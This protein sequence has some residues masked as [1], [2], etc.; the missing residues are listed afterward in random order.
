MNQKLVIMVLLAVPLMAPLPLA[1][2]AP[3]R[4]GAAGAA[5]RGPGR[6]TP[7]PPAYPDRP[8]ADPAVVQ[9]GKASYGVNCSFCHGS[10][11]RG[12]EGGPNLLRSE[13]MLDDQHGEKMAPIVKQGLADR[14][15]PKFDMT[16]AQIADVAAFIHSF[17]VGG[18]D[19]SRMTP[20]SVLVGDAKAGGTYFKSKCGACH[21][22]TGD[23]KGLASKITDPKVLQNTWLMP[24]GGRGGAAT[25]VPPIT[26]TVTLPSGKVEGRLDRIDDFIV[27]LVDADGRHRSFRR[28]GDTPKVEIHNPLQPHLDMLPN[29]DDKDIH[30]LTAYLVTLK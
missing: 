8:P 12:G 11:A 18:Y 23:L 16:D 30:N 25:N 14:G 15:M 24:G 10:D 29:Y 13:L 7:R 3:G 19:I 9:R 2:Q 22:V 1:A 26:V 27:G 4:A 21:S 5:G 20:P 28:D 17:K 6:G